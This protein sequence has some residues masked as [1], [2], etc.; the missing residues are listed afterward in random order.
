MALENG[1]PVQNIVEIK[2]T[3]E[4][5]VFNW[6][7]KHNIMEDAVE[8][9]IKEGFSSLT[10]IELLEMEDLAKT[11][12]SRGQQK[13]ILASVTKLNRAGNS[14]E[15]NDMAGTSTDVTSRAPH[16][17]SAPPSR[18]LDQNGDD[19]AA[20]SDPYLQILHQQLKAGQLQVC[21]ENFNRTNIS[22]DTTST[23][24]PVARQV[25]HSDFAGSWQDPQIY[26]ATAS[27]GKSASTCYQITDF[28]SSSVE[29]E[30]VV[31]NN[32]SH[33]VV[34]K[35]GPKK[36]KLENITFAQWS[37]SNLAILYKL[38][39]EGIL[40]PTG[41]MDYLS[42]TTK[43]CQLVQRYTLLSV[44]HYDQEYRQLQAQHNF[45]WGTDVPHLQTV[46]LVARAPKPLSANGKHFQPNLSKPQGHSYPCTLDGRI[47][48]KLYNTRAGCHY[49]DCKFVH[50]CSHVGCHQTHSAVT[51]RESKN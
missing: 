23:E 2:M 35:S 37:V 29:E 51:H 33:Q 27:S 17:A 50:A 42:Y 9:L 47:I 13:L 36:P 25:G 40:N 46:Y 49:T 28:M 45:R 30:V 20:T 7:A 5:A 44:L 3:E 31:G 10:A 14:T 19:S 11:K 39:G 48:C 41:I 16:Q 24:N 6:A 8:K 18:H 26:L 12:I 34:L 22:S 38:V 21:N 4:E 1:E 43:I 32:G 15:A